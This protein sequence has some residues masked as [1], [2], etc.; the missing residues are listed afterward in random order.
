[1]DEC[2]RVCELIKPGTAAGWRRSPDLCA[3][4]SHLEGFTTTNENKPKPFDPQT[5]F[6]PS[7][8]HYLMRKHIF[9]VP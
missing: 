2:A 6:T 4:K 7:Q 3:N 8:A 1:M 5:E 9:F